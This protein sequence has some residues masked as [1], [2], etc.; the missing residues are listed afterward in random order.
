LSLDARAIEANCDI[1]SITLLAEL[2]AQTI[3]QTKFDFP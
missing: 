1:A 2:L 3:A